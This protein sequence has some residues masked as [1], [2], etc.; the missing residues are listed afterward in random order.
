MKNQIRFG[1]APVTCTAPTN[2]AV[3]NIG[4]VGA[5]VSWEQPGSGDYWIVQCSTS[6][7]FSTFSEVTI[8]STS[9]YI[10][11]LNPNTTYY[12]RVANDCGS[13]GI[14]SWSNTVTFT[15]TES[16]C[17]APTNLTVSN[18]SYNNVMI[19]LF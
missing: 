15:T 2:L 5:G 7:D 10:Y 6:S 1:F 19:C 8:G 17:L 16:P 14:S 3:S 13:D 18:I 4:S 11:S 12:V 9:W